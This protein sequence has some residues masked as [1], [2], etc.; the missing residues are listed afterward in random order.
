MKLSI[1]L[2][3][4]ALMLHFTTPQL[5]AHCQVPCG[6]YSDETVLTDLQTHQKT[7]AKAMVQIDELSAK[8]AKEN[9]NQLSRWVSNKEEHATKIQDTMMQY[10]LAQR[11]KLGEED[12]EAYAKKLKLVH[13]ITVYAMKCKQTT[14]IENANKLKAAIDAFTTAYNKK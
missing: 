3:A 11:I 2:A 7:I 13:E 1:T 5:S 4:V 8:D 14:D 6:I 10:F 12:Q 9:V